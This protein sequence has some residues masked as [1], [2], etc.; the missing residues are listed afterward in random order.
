MASRKKII[1]GNEISKIAVLRLGGYEQKVLIEGK[2]KD[3]PVVINLH[4][5]PGMPIPF[6]VGCRGLFPEY[7]D[8]YIMVYWDQLGCGC[9]ADTRAKDLSVSDYVDMTIDLVHECKKMFPENKMIFL[10]ISF[11]TVLSSLALEREPKLVD[12]VLAWGQFVSEPWLNNEVIQDLNNHKIAP[13]KLKRF[14]ELT[15]EHFDVNGLQ[16]M[17]KVISKYTNG[18]TDRRFKPMPRAKLLKG[19]ITSPDYRFSALKTFVSNDAMLNI[20]IYKELLLL[21]ETPILEK[22]EIPYKILSGESDI[23][24]AS[25]S[26]L[27]KLMKS[28]NENL[29]VVEIKNSGHIPS[30]AAFEQVGEYLEEFVEVTACIL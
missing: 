15:P 25:K 2:R 20:S 10:A 22:I 12:G 8:K 30:L 1:A 28:R 24:C 6:C 3:L 16:F 5:G 9:N 29:S 4:G 26:S 18:Y 14:K 7:T 13:E 21:D 23:I 27:Q 17:Y 11:G 19:Y